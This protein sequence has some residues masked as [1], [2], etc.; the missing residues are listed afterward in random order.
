MMM[1]IVEVSKIKMRIMMIMMM[2]IMRMMMMMMMM[3]W[4]P[5]L[6]REESSHLQGVCVCVYVSEHVQVRAYLRV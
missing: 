1:V 2:M 3:V 5:R 4:V 6:V